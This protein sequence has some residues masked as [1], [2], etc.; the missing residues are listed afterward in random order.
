MNSMEKWHNTIMSLHCDPSQKELE[1]TR[2]VKLRSKRY[3]EWSAAN[4]NHTKAEGM[5]AYRK[6]HDETW[7]N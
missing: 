3:S 5:V 4:E 7:S 6:I 1:T 2:K